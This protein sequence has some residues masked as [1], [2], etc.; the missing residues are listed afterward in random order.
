[1]ASYH[2]DIPQIAMVSVQDDFNPSSSTHSH[3]FFDASR[4]RASTHVTSPTDDSAFLCSP[5]RI[6]RLARNSL[7]PPGAPLSCTFDASSR[8]LLLSPTLFSHSSGSTP[9]ATSTA[10]GDSRPEDYDILSS[11]R[12][13]TP[14]SPSHRQMGSIRTISSIGSTSTEP[15][16]K[17][18]SSCRL[19]PVCCAH[20]NATSTFSLTHARVDAGSD[21]GSRSPPQISFF[22]RALSHVWRS[23]PSPS[24]ETTD[25]GSETLRSDKQGSRQACPV[26]WDFKQAADLNDHK[27]ESCNDKHVN[28]SSR[29]PSPQE[30]LNDQGV[31]YNS[32]EILDDVRPSTTH[33]QSINVLPPLFQDGPTPASSYILKSPDKPRPTLSSWLKNMN[34]LSGLIDRLQELAS[35]SPAKHGSQLLSQVAT[36][37]AT[38]KKQQDRCIVFLELSEE[39]ATRYLLDISAEIQHQ[40]SFMDL[41]EK[42]LDVAKT[43]YGRAC[44]LRRS[45]ESGTV[46]TMKDDRATG[47]T[48]SCHL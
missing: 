39:C 23:S 15:D 44:D 45:H 36:L 37:R 20:P 11:S 38:F 35:S 30:A 31:R 4:M 13:L 3:S 7:Y 26:V 19:G 28:I 18:S 46:N 17:D 43:L 27:V 34:E 6:L 29:P 14:S 42:R 25:A 10:L 2:L 16:I 24:Y 5:T 48:A 1:M 33:L 22:G 32:H 47:K 41:L 9:F 12:L 8:Y 21:V 40:S